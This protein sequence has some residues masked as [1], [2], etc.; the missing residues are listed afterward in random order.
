MQNTGTNAWPA[1]LPLHPHPFSANGGNE[2][3]AGG[4]KILRFYRK[5]IAIR[6][7]RSDDLGEVLR[8]RPKLVAHIDRLDRSPLMLLYLEIIQQFRAFTERSRPGS[9]CKVQID[10]QQL[11][12]IFDLGNDF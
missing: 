8:D 5:R 2:L 10:F 7:G 11:G 1:L 12:G 9:L 3:A 6:T 4:S